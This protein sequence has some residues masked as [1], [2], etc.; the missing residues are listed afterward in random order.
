MSHEVVITGVGPISAI[1]IGRED[2]FAGLAEGRIGIRPAETVDTSELPSELAA[3]CLDFFIE[4]YIESEKTYLDRTSA[5]ALAGCQLALDDAGLDARAMDHERIGLSLGT[6]CGCMKTMHDYYARV[7]AK[8]PRFASSVLFPHSYA[9]TPASLVSIEYRIM[10]PTNTVC[11][12]AA[13]ALSA[14][15]Y[16]FDLL[17]HDR[18]DAMLAG[19]VDS[20]SEPLLR[21]LSAQGMLSP[22]DGGEEAARPFDARRNGC[23]LGE[24]A[25]LLLMERA[26][27][28]EQRGAKPLGK[29]LGYGMAQGGA[30]AL[31]A[32]IRSALEDA[33]VEPGDV[34]AVFASANGSP[35]VDACEAEALAAVFGD[36]A[37][38]VTSP[39]S[40][41]GESIGASAGLSLIAA[42][43]AVTAGSIPPTRGFEQP[44]DGVSL[45]VLQ[46]PTALELRTC[47]VSC[48]DVSGNCGA[49]V[50]AA[51]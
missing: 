42:L 8:G 50:V 22:A 23:V 29:L 44:D 13:S 21:G 19:G 3:E 30:E 18:I 43:W 41:L 5:F 24:G 16:A 47:L 7:A 25:G 12:G 34:D 10:G 49:L 6:G 28:A 31:A 33:A 46:E 32:A 40:T 27:C 38:P 39:K 37:V 4:D 36:S 51:P 45:N 17:R 1:G 11:T 20:V 35:E 14:I 48:L 2:F 15:A 26:D 9:N